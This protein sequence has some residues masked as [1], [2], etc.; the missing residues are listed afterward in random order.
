[1]NFD[2]KNMYNLYKNFSAFCYGFIGTNATVS[3]ILEKF[4]DENDTIGEHVIYNF[5]RDAKSVMTGTALDGFFV[6]S[7]RG[8]SKDFIST[9]RFLSCQIFR[10]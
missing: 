9:A 2:K 4:A 1:M 5:D 6:T 3:V 7:M 10:A 8:E